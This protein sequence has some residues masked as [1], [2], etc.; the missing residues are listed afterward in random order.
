MVTPNRTTSNSR[1]GP[2]KINIWALVKQSKPTGNPECPTY[3][4]EA[5][6]VGILAVYM[7]VSVSAAEMPT[8]TQPQDKSAN[9]NSSN[10]TLSDK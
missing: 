8:T 3:I 10:I 5:K 9:H 1:T 4:H 2:L 7:P 6:A